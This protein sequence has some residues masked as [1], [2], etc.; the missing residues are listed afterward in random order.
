MV[1]ALLVLAVAWD[2]RKPLDTRGVG[3][4]LIAAA[5][6]LAMAPFLADTTLHTWNNWIP[7]MVQQTYGTEYARF[8]VETVSHPVRTLAVVLTGVA[9]AALA[10]AS[11]LDHSSISVS[12][13]E[14]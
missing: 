9:I 11:V 8:G 4:A 2:S 6:T 14:E 5:V 10:G 3:S 13:A 12:E 1:A 7:A